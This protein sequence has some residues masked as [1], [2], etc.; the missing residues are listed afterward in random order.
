MSKHKMLNNTIY[1]LRG[2]VNFYLS[3]SHCQQCEQQN[4]L[5]LNDRTSSLKTSILSNSPCPMILRLMSKLLIS[6][7]DYF[8]RSIKS[9]FL[10]PLPT[11]ILIEGSSILEMENYRLGFYI[12]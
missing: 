3:V 6:K 1:S 7:S 12:S 4:T 8:L 10:P 2:R 9:H 5:P 11:F